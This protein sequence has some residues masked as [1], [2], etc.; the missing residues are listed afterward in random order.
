M[1]QV[2]N[3]GSVVSTNFLNAIQN[4]QFNKN[5]GEVLSDGEYYRLGNSS[6]LNQPGHIVY[7]FYNSQ[8][9]FLAVPTGSGLQIGVR[10]GRAVRG[11]GLAIDVPYTTINAIDNKLSYI[12]LDADGIVAIDTLLPGTFVYPIARVV[13]ANGAITALSDIR[14]KHQIGHLPDITKVLGGTG[15]EGDFNSTGTHVFDKGIYYF[16]NFILNGGHHIIIERFARIHVA[17]NCFLNGFV[18]V[19][20]NTRGGSGVGTGTIQGLNIGKFSGNGAGGGGSTIGNSYNWQV[21]PVGS[22]GS[23]GIV[24]ADG[25]STGSPVIIPSGGTGGGGVIFEVAE[26]LNVWGVVNANGTNGEDGQGTGSYSLSAGGGGGSGGTLVFIAGERITT[27][28][29]TVISARGGNGGRGNRTP[30][31]VGKA[32]GGAG[33]GA[34]QVVMIAPNFTLDPSTTYNL[35]GGVEGVNSDGNR[36]RVNK[37]MVGGGNGGGNGGAGGNGGGLDNSG[38]SGANSSPIIRTFRPTA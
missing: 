32:A 25:Q 5:P 28:P 4:L 11:S 33:G 13:A 35:T 3:N 29:Q 22:G 37:A 24:T 9:E 23:S 21:S 2:F 20:P 30:G 36:D 6:L 18:T 16:D 19:N 1:K 31:T 7:D 14:P 8:N 12:Y 17:R 27:Q 15:D 34:G 26:N 10:A 38:H